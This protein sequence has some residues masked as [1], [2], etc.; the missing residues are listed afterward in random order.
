MTSLDDLIAE[1]LAALPDRPALPANPIRS[2]RK[3]AQW[4]AA[5]HRAYS[6]VSGRVRDPA[7]Q[8]ALD[9]YYEKTLEEGPDFLKVRREADFK[10]VPVVAYKGQGRDT[11]KNWS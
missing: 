5:I 9:S 10:P 2:T 3:A 4:S 8:A 11:C 6:Y 1:R 7:Q